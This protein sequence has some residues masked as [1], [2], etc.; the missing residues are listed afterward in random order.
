MY[1]I[2]QKGKRMDNKKQ[3]TVTMNSRVVRDAGAILQDI[4]ILL[5]DKFRRFSSSSGKESTW[6]DF[7]NFKIM[8]FPQIIKFLWL[9]GVIASSLIGMVQIVHGIANGAW[10]FC[11]IGL[12][13]LIFSP[14]VT[15][16]LLEFILL[17]FSI[18][19]ILRDIRDKEND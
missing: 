10:Q 15:H 7:C 5:R 14:I 13:V 18:L 8:L 1:T 16:L 12:L 4:K 11:G 19:E 3:E 9:L 17:P 2:Q 6:K